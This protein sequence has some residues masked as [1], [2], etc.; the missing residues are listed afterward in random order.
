MK[1]IVTFGEHMD[2]IEAHKYSFANKKMLEE[3]L[4]CG[5]F[6]CGAIFRPDEIEE[7]CE[8]K[9]EWTALCPYCGIDA[10]IGGSIGYPLTKESLDI[11]YQVW[12]T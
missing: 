7:W 6:Y 5:C 2:C 3:E 1:N 9:P 11:M 8:D 4:A 12:F 10:V